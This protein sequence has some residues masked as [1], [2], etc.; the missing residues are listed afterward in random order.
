MAGTVTSDLPVEPLGHAVLPGGNS[1]AVPVAKQAAP[2]ARRRLAR[3]YVSFRSRCPPGG[4]TLRKISGAVAGQDGCD[5]KSCPA[6]G[7]GTIGRHGGG[8][9]DG[10]RGHSGPTELKR[11]TG[12]AETF[13]MSAARCVSWR[14]RLFMTLVW[15]DC[16]ALRFHCCCDDISAMQRVTRPLKLQRSTGCSLRENDSR[17][18][19]NGPSN[20]HSHRR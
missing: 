6:N 9:P 17:T 2:V 12:D 8:A 20:A 4:S 16:F 5:E 3:G 18:G 19:R 13:T 7:P 10:D 11:A 14:T 1:K 15:R